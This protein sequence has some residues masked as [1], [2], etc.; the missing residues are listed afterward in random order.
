MG[1]RSTFEQMIQSVSNGILVT[2]ISGK[3]EFI[4]RQAEIILGLESKNIINRDVSAV[5]PLTGPQVIKCLKTGKPQLGHHIIGKDISL[6][7]NITTIRKDSQLQGVICCFQGMEEFEVSAKKLESYRRQNVELNAIFESSSDGIWVCD[8]DAKVI[9]INPASEKINGLMAKD[10]IGKHV[11]ELMEGG[12]FDHSVTLEVLEKKQQVSVYQYMYNTKKSLLVTGTPVLDEKGDICMVVLNERDMTQLNNVT[13]QL[14][15]HRKV[16][17]KMKDELAELAM[18]E[19]KREGIVAVSESMKQCMRIA[20][21]L[22]NIKASNILIL[23]ESGTGKGLLARFIHQNDKNPFVQ[24]NCA[25]L[26]ESLLEAELFGYEKGA[27][28]GASEHGKVGLFELAQGGTIFLD[29]IGELPLSSQAKLLKYLDDHEIIRIGG[30]K[31]KRIDCTVVAAT[32]RD[33]EELV[34]SKKFRQDLFYRLNTFT[35]RIPALRERPED[36]FEL[37]NFFLQKYNKQYQMKRRIVPEAYALLQTYS[38]PGNIRELN[39]IIQKV[40]VL[41]END[42][43]D[44]QMLKRIERKIVI[45]DYA[46]FHHKKYARIKDQLTAMEQEILRTTMS[47]FKSTREMAR[48]LGISQP[49][50]VRKMQKYGFKRL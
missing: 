38:F 46:D 45:G 24:I 49:T 50:I 21:K 48:H 9:D 2:D 33:L 13:K 23:G 25:A 42:D 26:P 17:E 41:S 27:F 43:V 47:Q 1:E 10:I 6:V 35:I 20:H 8:K 16:A 12:F 30:T 34:R 4:N 7:L 11:S 44:E 40:V 29:E 36:L 18:L 19:I 15:E 22:A 37:I 14:E 5:L 31:P 3:I 28:T 39:N 32:N